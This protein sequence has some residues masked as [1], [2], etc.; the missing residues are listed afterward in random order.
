MVEGV[1]VGHAATH[2]VIAAVV[3]MD[4]TVQPPLLE[5][6]LLGFFRQI[7]AFLLQTCVLHGGV[8]QE[9]GG[10][11]DAAAPVVLVGVG[12]VIS[13]DGGHDELAPELLG[14][15]EMLVH[16]AALLGL[17]YA[18]GVQ[19]VEIG[20]GDAAGQGAVTQILVEEQT[21]VLVP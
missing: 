17:G 4:M 11:P 14:V 1:A 8:G 15:V 12:G 18:V 6:K 10:C 16:H 9:I 7:T 19:S 21:E 2:T 20:G 13:G 5:Q 3:F